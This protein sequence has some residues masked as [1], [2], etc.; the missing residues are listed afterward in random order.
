MPARSRALGAEGRTQTTKQ[1]IS[2]GDSAVEEKRED[3]DVRWKQNYVN[4]GRVT[5]FVVAVGPLAL[6]RSCIAFV[7][8]QSSDILTG[9]RNGP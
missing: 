4:N 8:N 2:G 7:N 1:M 3:V 5:L 6:N 9:A